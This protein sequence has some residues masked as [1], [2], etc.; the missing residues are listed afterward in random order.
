MSQPLSVIL[1]YKEDKIVKYTV[2]YSTTL[3]PYKK[4]D[5][6]KF[7]CYTKKMDTFD[8]RFSVTIFFHLE[9]SGISD[10]LVHVLSCYVGV[11]SGRQHN[12]F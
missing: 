8:A 9:V 12:F 11:T 5:L 10:L 1:I 6:T 3:S 7:L 4:N 2:L